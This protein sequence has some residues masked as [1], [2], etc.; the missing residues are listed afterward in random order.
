[1]TTI[2]LRYFADD[3]G[4]EGKQV[5]VANPSGNPVERLDPPVKQAR[6]SAPAEK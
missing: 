5:L 1:M 2:S 6:T 4:A 3:I